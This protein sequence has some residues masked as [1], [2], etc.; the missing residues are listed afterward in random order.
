MKNL[1]RGTPLFKNTYHFFYKEAFK[2][3]IFE[4]NFTFF[5]LFSGDILEHSGGPLEL[6]RPH[7]ENPCSMHL[8]T[9]INISSTAFISLYDHFNIY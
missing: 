2:L 7:F 1:L 9:N 3:N 8:Q 4:K 6:S 5:A